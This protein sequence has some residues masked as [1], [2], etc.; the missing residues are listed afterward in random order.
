MFTLAATTQNFSIYSRIYQVRYVRA[1][2]ACSFKPNGHE[3]IIVR[4]KAR[5]KNSAPGQN[6]QKAK[7]A[8]GVVQVMTSD[9]GNGG[10]GEIASKSSTSK[11]VEIL[12]DNEENA[13]TGI[14]EDKIISVKVKKEDIPKCWIEVYLQMP[15]KSENKILKSKQ[16]AKKER[17][18]TVED[19]AK[20]DS[21]TVAKTKER[22]KEGTT[23]ST[24]S[25]DEDDICILAAADVSSDGRYVQL[26]L[27]N[28]GSKVGS[29]IDTPKSFEPSVRGRRPFSYV[30][31][32]DATGIVVDVT[33]RYS[34]STANTKKVRPPQI[35]WWEQLVNESTARNKG[36]RNASHRGFSATLNQS[37]V[38]SID[39][40]WDSND[41]STSS[42]DAENK[43]KKS[44]QLA[45]QRCIEMDCTDEILSSVDH[46][47]QVDKA[48]RR[49]AG[50]L[51]AEQIE[52][53]SLALKEPMPTTLNGFKNHPL[54]I[55]E[56]DIKVRERT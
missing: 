52:F 28:G 1:I 23:S 14:D 55:L 34:N 49:L 41:N 31:A 9:S 35:E 12:S 43:G 56:R 30:I 22:E 3:D 25:T 32:V 21:Q 26:D 18:K 19:N 40:E 5:A 39:D 24:R 51:R 47:R 15:K 10:D 2:D 46:G 4:A 50:R 53:Q 54:Y 33:S 48:A 16:G 6:T 17:K 29:M 27:F 11:V 13:E 8:K 37:M 42:Y 36:V 44:T 38:V 7:W 45:L 20:I